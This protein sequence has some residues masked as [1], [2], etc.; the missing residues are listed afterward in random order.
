MVRTSGWAA[1]AETWA[2]TCAERMASVMSSPS[3]GD[4]FGRL[5]PQLA[6]QQGDL[7]LGARVDA[8]AEHR[9]GDGPVHGAGL[10]DGQPEGGG[11][12]PGHRRLPRPGRAVDGQDRVHRCPP[13]PPVT[14]SR[15]APKPG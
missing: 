10:Q 9:P 11:H 13:A 8:L 2:V 14:R 6:G 4:P 5:D 12:G 1:T 15:S 3:S 7:G